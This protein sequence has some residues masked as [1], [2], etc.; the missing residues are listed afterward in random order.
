MGGESGELS[1]RALLRTCLARIT[2]LDGKLHSVIEVNPEAPAIAAGLDRERKR[3]GPRG[4]LHGLPILL[5]DNIDTADQMQTTAGSLALVGAPPAQDAR[6]V[7]RLREA[8]AVML[9]KANLSEW[10]NF[11]STRSS[12]G[13]SAR[14]GQC[15]NPHVLDRT[16]C[17][18]SSGSA[19]A[20]AAGLC[21]AALG[22]E[23]DGS[24]VCPSSACGVV[25]VKP[26]VGLTST[27]GVVP[28][29]HSQDT[30]GVHARSVA[31]AARVLEAIAEGDGG[32]DLEGAT[33]QGARIG[34]V[35]ETYSGL[36]EH[37]DRVFNQA[38]DL[39]RAKG[40]ELVDPA[41][42]A[43]SAEMRSAGV[44][45]TVLLY[46]FKHDLNAYLAGRRGVPVQSL[47]DLIEFNRKQ[48]EREMPYF[49]QE[50]LEAA[51]AKGG[52]EENEYVQ[53][54][55]KSRLL[56]RELGIDASL[57][58][59]GVEALVAPTLA[60]A[61]TIDLLNGDRAVGSSSQAAAMAGYPLVTVP[62]GYA[63]GRLPVGITFMGTAFGERTLLRLAYAF[64]TAAGAGRPPDLLSTLPL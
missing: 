62:A 47:E 16:P 46:E 50:R 59:H 36:S 52:L 3:Q 51:Q 55:A 56:S 10:A 2:R 40:A 53:A 44:E 26:T 18:S 49:G 63:F 39:M 21:T 37:T 48:A 30:V 32:Y 20:V 19:V 5:K 22:T 7:A 61:W 34:V 33:L 54:L 12:S 58:K 45:L 4:P 43:T 9:G 57:A 29:A 42:I 1:A 27:A 15:R 11:R 23:T 35:R 25:G 38:L 31:D 24:I 6:V 60:P 17:G 64:E 8:G 41:N 14:G 28:I 13:W